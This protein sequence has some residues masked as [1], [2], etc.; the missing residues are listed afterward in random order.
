MNKKNQLIL[1]RWQVLA[2]VDKKGS[3][4]INENNE[5][6]ADILNR[7]SRAVS[8]VKAAI[9]D[10]NDGELASVLQYLDDLKSIKI[11]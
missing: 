9:N 6:I 11:S 4:Q 5:N 7:Y 2:G 8:D 3:E 1:E 10:I